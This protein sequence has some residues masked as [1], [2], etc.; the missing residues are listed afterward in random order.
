MEVKTNKLE[1]ILKKKAG[2][3]NVISLYPVHNDRWLVY[4]NHILD[5]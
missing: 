3:N 5:N 2:Q 4:S 1:H